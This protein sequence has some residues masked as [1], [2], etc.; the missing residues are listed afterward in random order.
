VFAFAGSD[1]AA[2]LA[3]AALAGD[4]M[5]VF[6]AGKAVKQAAYAIQKQPW[7]LQDIANHDGREA[8]VKSLSKAQMPITPEDTAL[9]QRAASGEAVMG[10]TADAARPP[11]SPL[12]AHAVALAA[13][14]AIGQAGDE[15]V[16]N[17]NWLFDSYFTDRCLADAKRAL[18]ECL[19]VAKPNYEDVFC[20]GQHEM[21][22][23]GACVVK[24]A[25]S[26][27]PLEILTQ[28]LHVPPAHRHSKRR[29]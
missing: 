11:Y 15:Q 17:L 12:I 4:G 22:D 5:R 24:G 25:G 10:L 28:P 2:A 23:T 8:D 13:L 1:R 9:L 16:D 19:A 27:V 6:D 29:G 7:S 20:I 26:T 14:A 18:Y 3:K 21:T